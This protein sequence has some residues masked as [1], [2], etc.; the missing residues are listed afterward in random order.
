[1]SPDGR[2]FGMMQ[3]TDPRTTERLRVKY[4]RTR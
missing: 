3:N 2:R 1:V 4:N